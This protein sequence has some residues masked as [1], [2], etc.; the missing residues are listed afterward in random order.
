MPIV[1]LSE[2]NLRPQVRP[3]RSGQGISLLPRFP[4]SRVADRT[5][6]PSAVGASC[7]SAVRSIPWL[8]PSSH[9]VLELWHII[10]GN[11]VVGRGCREIAMVLEKCVK[12]QK[13]QNR[14]RN[15]Q[16]LIQYVMCY[17][18]FELPY[19]GREIQVK[20]G[21]PISLQASDLK[22]HLQN[23]MAESVPLFN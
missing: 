2:R 8:L 5:I 12:L 3:D 13:A 23:P 17:G 21:R 4:R 14:H 1:A 6:L 9:H 7:N 20:D 11:E 22:A 16:K 18:E 10:V 15:F 19:L